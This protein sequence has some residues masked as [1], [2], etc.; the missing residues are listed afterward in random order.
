MTSSLVNNPFTTSN[1]YGI[2]CGIRVKQN[3]GAS[4]RVINL[5]L[6][7]CV[8]TA[9]SDTGYGVL[10]TLNLGTKYFVYSEDNVTYN[11]KYTKSV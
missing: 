10:Y 9:D 1:N 4:D 7:D 6:K 2:G 5:T 8:I 3:S 11:A